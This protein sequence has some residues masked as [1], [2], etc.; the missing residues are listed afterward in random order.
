MARCPLRTCLASR[1]TSLPP[2]PSKT[3]GGGFTSLAL[4]SWLVCRFDSPGDGLLRLAE[5][6]SLDHS[7]PLRC[8]A[9]RGPTLF[10]WRVASA[11]VNSAAVVADSAVPN[12]RCSIRAALSHQDAPLLPWALPVHISL[13]LSRAF[14]ALSRR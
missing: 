6:W 10:A 13:R 11:V 14:C 8:L 3:D 4:P 2:L 5:A 7:S 9:G 1:P 12:A